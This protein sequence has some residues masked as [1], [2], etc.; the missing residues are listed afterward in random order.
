MDESDSNL[1]SKQSKLLLYLSLLY[2][3]LTDFGA[4]FLNT[5]VKLTGALAPY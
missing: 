1:K 4:L 3:W 5:A 2:F